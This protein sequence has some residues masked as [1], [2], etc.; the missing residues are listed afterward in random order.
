MYGDFSRVLDGLSGQYSAVLAQQ[1]RFLLDAELNEQTTILLDY[2]RQ[3]TVD[4]I[5]PFAGPFYDCGFQVTPVIENDKCYA[6]GLSKGHYYVYGV[7]CEAPAPHRPADESIAIGELDAPFVVY[8]LVWEQAVSANQVPELTDPAL[9]NGVPDT[10]RRTQVRWRPVAAQALAGVHD[11]LPSLQAEEIIRCSHSYNTDLR[12]RPRLGA[13]AHSD[14]DQSPGPGTAPVAGGYRGVENQLYRVEVHRGG[15]ADEA[16]FKWSRDNGSVE[17]GVADLSEI[18]SEG[19]R[20][21]TLRTVWYDA[22][23]GLA[24]G[25]WVELVDDRWAPLG[26]PAPLMQVQEVSLSARRVVLSDTAADRDVERSARLLLRRWDQDPQGHAPQHGIAI[27]QAEGRWFEL[28]DGVQVRFEAPGARYERG[29]Y[30]LIPARTA[31]H[32]VLWPRSEA[33]PRETPLLPPNGPARY[34]APL[35]LVKNLEE[36]PEDL[37]LR[38][39]YHGQEAGRSEDPSSSDAPTSTSTPTAGQSPTSAEPSR[40]SADETETGGGDGPKTIRPPAVT[41]RVRS[42]SNVEPGAVFTVHEGTTVGRADDAGIS[43]QH[44]DISRHH[45]MFGIENGALTIMDLGSTNGT[46]VNHERVPERTPT[47]LDPGDTIEIG[48]P[49]LVLQVEEE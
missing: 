30:W 34:L 24:V 43:I 16:T 35:A 10:T 19:N 7:R 45:A 29:D 32:G 11:D 48:S 20:T 25:D 40:A 21:A 4:L 49:D 13:R 5:G 26:T 31:I 37:R 42:V 1:G 6:V 39:R 28:E 38:F 33:D 17:F 8:L 14:S 9:G 36:E 41:Y 23:S 27:E 22:R 2:L 15:P 47:V 3:L 44:P 46:A 18:D 12:R